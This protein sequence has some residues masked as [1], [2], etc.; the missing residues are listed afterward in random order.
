MQLTE[1]QIERLKKLSSININGVLLD[2]QEQIFLCWLLKKEYADLSMKM[3]NTLSD[4]SFSRRQAKDEMII[5]LKLLTLIERSNKKW[6]LEL[7]LAKEK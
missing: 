1:K 2:D 7:S 6:I 5:C 4:L 3:Q